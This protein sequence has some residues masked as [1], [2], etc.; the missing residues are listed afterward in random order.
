MKTSSFDSEEH[1]ILESY[2]RGEWASVANLEEEIRQYR[3]HAAATVEQD[4]S[5]RVQLAPEDLEAIQQQAIAEGVS[6]QTL[7][8]R[9]VHEFVAGH[10]VERP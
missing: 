5:V 4:Q 9:I 2:D 1:D 8:A 10:L 7:I 6:S 3:A